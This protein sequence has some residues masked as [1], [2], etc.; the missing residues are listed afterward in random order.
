MTEKSF[1]PI[2]SEPYFFKNSKRYPGQSL[3]YLALNNSSA[4]FTLKDRPHKEGDSML[5]HI[6]FLL[7]AGD[8][9][10]IKHMCPICNQKPVKFLLFRNSCFLTLNLSCCNDPSCKEIIQNGSGDRLIA[11]KLRNLRQFVKKSN[12][13]KA[14]SIYRQLLFLRP[15]DGS[16]RVFEAIT[17][18]YRKKME[19]TNKSPKIKPK[20]SNNKKQL[21]CF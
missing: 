14:E 4:F 3:E 11:V 7:T 1:N 2:P 19:E 15:S 20:K 8:Y 6:D 18:K 9:M 16:Y 12:K 10:D 17:S 21:R 5:K 13:K